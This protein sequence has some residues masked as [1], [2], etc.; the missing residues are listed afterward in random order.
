MANQKMVRIDYRLIHGQIV[1]KWIKFRPVDRLII[2]DDELLNDEFMSD[3]YKMAVPEN[4]VDVVGVDGLQEALN[5][6]NDNVMVIFK[7]VA[8]AKRAFDNGVQLA[9]LNV[10]AIQSNKGR[11]SVT[12]GVALSS[13]EF[14][15][16]TE[17]KSNGVD[18]YIQ[19]IPENDK[20]TLESVKNKMI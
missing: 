7:D 16:L 8:N 4:E 11:Q 6:K 2:A 14:D 18:V 19:P 12:P 20:L 9:E 5:R 1:A 15:V 10:G 3:I 13:E 17:M